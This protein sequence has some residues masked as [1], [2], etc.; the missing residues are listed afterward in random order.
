MCSGERRVPGVQAFSRVDRFKNP[1]ILL[2]SLTQGRAS[3]TEE[4]NLEVE[5]IAK[6]TNL[7]SPGIK[8]KRHQKSSGFLEKVESRRVEMQNKKKARLN[9]SKCP[10]SFG[11]R[12]SRAFR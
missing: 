2:F 8:Q 3:K 6:E 5:R 4:D 7:Y 11:T 12:N 10:P 9:E 1:L